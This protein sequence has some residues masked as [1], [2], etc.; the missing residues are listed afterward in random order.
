MPCQSPRNALLLQIRKSGTN[1]YEPVQ[2]LSEINKCVEDIYTTVPNPY[3]L[4]NSISPE[5]QVCSFLKDAFFSLTLE[6]KS[7]PIFVFKWQDPDWGF[8][9][10]F[11]WTR[12]P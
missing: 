9:G 1:D 5:L 11:N 8:S 12:L 6:V 3:N 10:Q 4:L 7:Q 2:S